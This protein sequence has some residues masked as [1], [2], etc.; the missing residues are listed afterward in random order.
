MAR[1]EENL[2]AA[3]LDLTPD[4]LDGIDSAVSKMALQGARYPEHLEKTT[5]R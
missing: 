5:N 1:L 2:A 3:S 4:D